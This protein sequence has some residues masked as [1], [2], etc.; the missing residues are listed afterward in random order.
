MI[1]LLEEYGTGIK[2][3]KGPDNGAEEALSRFPL[4]NY[5]VKES[6]ITR[7]NL[8]EMYCVDK[9]CSDTFPLI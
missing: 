9:V 4:I 3:I 8:V 7:E 6:D 1:L 2:Y 5:D